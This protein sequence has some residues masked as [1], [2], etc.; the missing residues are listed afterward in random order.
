MHRHL[1][2]LLI[3]QEMCMAARSLQI[4]LGF[5]VYLFCLCPGPSTHDTLIPAAQLPDCRHPSQ[6]HWAKREGASDT[7]YVP[8]PGCLD[9][10][11]I[12]NAA[13][14]QLTSD[15]LV[16][17]LS[18]AA[19]CGFLCNSSPRPRPLPS[20]FLAGIWLPF[21]AFQACVIAVLKRAQ[22]LA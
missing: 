19:T 20:R 15:I 6:S 10:L 14:A 11:D 8:G 13:K 1:L 5:C 22:G 17:G 4:N 7:I 12:S 9:S 2:R 18:T 21:C 16:G 3:V